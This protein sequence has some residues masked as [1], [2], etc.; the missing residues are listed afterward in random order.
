MKTFSALLFVLLFSTS[1]FAATFTVN[2]SNDSSDYDLN[3]GECLDVNNFCTL[4]A[5]VEQANAS[6]TNDEINFA[7]DVTVTAIAT[8]ITITNNGSLTINGRGANVSTIAK[9][10]ATTGRVLQSNGATLTLRNLTVTGGNFSQQLE[11]A[12]GMLVNG[13]AVTL[14]AVVFDN[15]QNLTGR[16]SAAPGGAINFAGGT[17]TIR[18]STFSNNTASGN[19]GGINNSG[20]LSVTNSTFSGNTALFIFGGAIANTGNLSLSNVTISNNTASASCISSCTGLGGGLSHSTGAL[21]FSNTI[22]SG[23]T[24]TG[25]SAPSGSLEIFFDGSGT[26]TSLGNNFVGDSAGDSS[27]TQTPINYQPTD[28]RDIAPRLATLANYGGATPTL[29]L[30]SNSPAINAGNDANAPATDQRGVGRIG[31]ADIGAFE[32]NG[33]NLT[34]SGRVTSD[35]TNG[36]GGVTVT[37]SG[38]SSAVVTTNANGEYSFATLIE[39]GTYTV[40]PTLAGTNFSPP[41]TTYVNL[42]GSQTANFRPE[43]VYTLNPA[44]LTLPATAG[45]GSISV[46]TSPGCS[47]TALA[48]GAFI[49]LTNAAGTGSGVV[50]FNVTANAGAVRTG[51]ITIAGQTV[52]VTQSALPTLSINNISLFEGNGG[53][54]AFA[55]TVNLSAA[56]SQTVTV[57]YAT[58][59]GTATPP[60]DYQAASGTL[61]FAP[62]ETVKTVTITVNG[63]TTVEPNETFTVNLSG[64]ANAGIATVQGTGTIRNDDGTAAVRTRFD[65]D[66]DGRA[67]VSLFRPANGNWY[68]LPSQTNAFYGFPFGQAGDQ[69]APADYDADGKTDVAVFRDTVP[70]AGNFAYFYILNSSDNS[71]RAVQFGA[72]GDVPVAGDWDGDGRGDF[73][74]YRQ[75][76]AA[77]GQSFFYYRPSSQPGVDFNTLPLG[78]FGDK[79]LLGDF[80]ADG[81]LDPAVFR[82]ASATWIILRSSVNQITQTNFGVSTD[83]PVPADYDGDGAANIAVFRP[84]NGFWYTSQNPQTNFG[85]VQFGAAGDAPVPADYDG[86]GRAD[87][88]VF[89]PSNGAWF[90]N[91]STSGFT[92]VSFGAN[93]DKPSPN[94]FIR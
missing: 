59:N 56:S 85:A 86:D 55:F 9:T 5:A 25:R 8:Q 69:I 28:I 12:P 65:Y 6:A 10:S 2:N 64:A 63:D 83:I 23:N 92:G 74:V 44:S 66:G 46:T 94:A 1:I 75:A 49:S 84:S 70:G 4:R 39:G 62:G 43:C 58:I 36:L 40:T 82:P 72:T 77:G 3:D 89:R 80:D 15:N 47:W 78:T 87:V 68:I 67:D 38:S 42:A 21:T 16:M 34:I 93:G 60:T 29:A 7:A 26:F 54:T 45:T 13:G 61:A 19:G 41:N 51:T 14:E 18:N 22:I 88:A 71:F 73:A 91:R 31:A 11:S 53:T 57:N 81:R 32:F 90:L 30:L 48:N 50:T 52:T 79:P 35:G 24:V 33:L 17:H 76:T 20:A 27:N 37:L